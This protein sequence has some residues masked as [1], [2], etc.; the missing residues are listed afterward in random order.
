M[1]S[2][3]LDDPD[4]LL[5]W[6]PIRD[7]P[8]WFEAAVA[9][10]QSALTRWLKTRDDG[11]LDALAAIWNDIV[12]G[13]DFERASLPFRMDLLNRS[14]VA[15]QWK[16]LATRSSATLEMAT[17]RLDRALELAPAGEPHRARYLSNLSSVFLLRFDLGDGPDALATGL[18]AALA[19]IDAAA[20][21]PSTLA[22]A[23][24]N[25]A[26]AFAARY[27]QHGN[28]ADLDCAVDFAEA[29]LAV[30]EAARSTR[31][32]RY[33]LSFA[34]VLSFRFDAFN[35]IDDLNR[36]IEVLE[37]SAGRDPLR[38][39]VSGAAV[40]GSLLRRRWS[41]LGDLA[42]LNRAVALL[43][44]AVSGTGGANRPALLTNLG[45]A[46][47]DRYSVTDEYDDLRRASASH[48]RAVEITRPDDW[49]LASRHNNAGNTALSIY[50]A[51]GESEA[52]VRAI[53][54]YRRAV[55]LTDRTAPELASRQYNLGNALRASHSQSGSPAE[56]AEARQTFRDACVN[57]LAAGLQWALAASLSWGGWASWRRDWGEAAAAYGYGMEAIDNLFRRQL[58]REEKEAW[59]RQAQGLAAAAGFALA[60]HAEPAAATTAIERGRAFLFS[61][62]LERDRAELVEVERAGRRDLVDRYRRASDRLRSAAGSVTRRADGPRA[63]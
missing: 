17:Q 58:A 36:G 11:D 8:A 32:A 12:E 62:V 42:D 61:E 54:H 51:S 41:I 21:D 37:R 43:D 59:L 7:V 20:D 27:R 24:S 49:Q 31:V 5:E 53:N 4:A 35:E 23:R 29:A 22:L 56:A 33:R 28:L 55:A 60:M 47:L 63:G 15:L 2:G 19:A 9:H 45:N 34:T 50:E 57:G 14:A 1:S 6:A 48:E 46:L 16:G 13:K 18:D 10:G 25:A 30:G 40:L 44:Q 39:A 38:E 3:R 26:S 52:L